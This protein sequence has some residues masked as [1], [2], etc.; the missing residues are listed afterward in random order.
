MAKDIVDIVIEKEYIE[1][2]AQER[3]E[4]AELCSNEDEFNQMKDVLSKVGSIEFNDIAPSADTKARLDDLFHDTYPKATPVW[5]MSALAVVVPNDKPF[6]RQPLLKVAAIALLFI[7]VYPLFNQDVVVNDKK[8]LAELETPNK[9]DDAN[10]DDV[11]I[12]EEPTFNETTVQELNEQEAIA[13]DVPVS[14]FTWISTGD[15][16][17]SDIDFE[18]SASLV[19]D[20]LSIADFTVATATVAGAPGMNHPDGIFGGIA[21]NDARSISAAEMPDVLDLLT[22]TF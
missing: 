11:N 19:D 9:I 21:A 17:L 5:Y 22:S 13:Q 8:Q 15:T 14:P 16:R 20:E 7:M 1:L 2:T 10:K 3:A 4:V 6:I 12:T 18:S